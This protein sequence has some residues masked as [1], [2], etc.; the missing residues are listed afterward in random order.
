MTLSEFQVEVAQI[1]SD[2]AGG[3]VRVSEAIQ[4]LCEHASAIVVLDVEAKVGALAKA[5]TFPPGALVLLRG[6]LAC[7]REDP[8]HFGSS[9]CPSCKA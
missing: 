8:D 7:P 3:S 4:K 1:I 6:I 5:Y 9:G 2:V